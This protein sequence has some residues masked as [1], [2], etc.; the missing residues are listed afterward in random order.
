MSR[1]LAV[2]AVAL[3]LGG[4]VEKRPG[5]L[6]TVTEAEI[7]KHLLTA[8]PSNATPLNASFGEGRVSLLGYRLSA[9]EVK[10]GKTVT[11]TF[12][13]RLEKRIDRTWKLF[14][15]VVDESGTPRINA[16]KIGTIRNGYQPGRWKVGQVVEDVQK[17]RILKN[18]N[19]PTAEFRVGIWRG[20]ERMSIQGPTDGKRRLVGVRVAVLGGKKSKTGEGAGL[21]SLAIPRAKRAVKIDGVLRPQEW[22]GAA[23]VDRLERPTTGGVVETPATTAKLLW[24]EKHLYVAFIC[25]DAFIQSTYAKHDDELWNQDVVEVFLDPDGDG[26]NYY[27]LQASPAGVTFDSFLPEY[28]KNQN[29]WES[30][31]NAAARVDGTLNSEKGQD[32]AW[33]VEMAIPFSAIQHAPSSPP[34]VGDTWRA[35]LFRIDMKAS[36]FQGM[37]WSPP[38]KPDYHVVSRFGRWTFQETVQPTETVAPE[39]DAAP[40]AKP[41]ALSSPE[42]KVEAGT[43]R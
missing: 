15:H 42:G 27:E 14:T 18:W 23:V 8:M 19:W 7:K 28:R 17:I 16:D 29:D 4:C 43:T 6:Q 12:Y 33:T 1:R 30:G 35:N 13:W 24:D 39:P 26:K 31:M 3:V 22:E 37:A 40:E 21:K 5:S 34:K 9:T 20:N 38:M 2:L 36:G 32:T 11:V 10:P 41:A 25:E